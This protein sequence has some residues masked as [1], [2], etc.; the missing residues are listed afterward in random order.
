MCQFR[1]VLEMA[2]VPVILKSLVPSVLRDDGEKQQLIDA[3][4]RMG[5]EEVHVH[6]T[7]Y[8]MGRYIQCMKYTSCRGRMYL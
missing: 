6:C 5:C 7:G 2:S 4:T 1:S 3:L 8:K